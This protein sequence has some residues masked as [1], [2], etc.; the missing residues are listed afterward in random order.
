MAGIDAK[1]HICKYLIKE[2]FYNVEYYIVVGESLFLYIK[3][4]TECI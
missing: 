3:F 2:L 1:W 4:K